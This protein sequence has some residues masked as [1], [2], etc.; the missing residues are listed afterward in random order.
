MDRL[1]VTFNAPY[2]VEIRRE[3]PAEP[4][5]GQVVVHTICSAVSAGSELLI[6]RGLA[7][8]G[9]AVDETIAAL[10]GE[11]GYPIKYG[12][13]AAGRVA[14]LG[15]QVDKSWQDRLVFAF[16]PHESAFVAD[17]ESLIR[18]PEGVSAETA[19]LLPSM[20]T[21][22]S[23]VMDAQP[24]I[25][26]RVAI[27]GQGVVGLLVTSLLAGWP[28]EM[29][30]TADRIQRRRQLSAALGAGASLDPD[31]P[32]IVAQAS[33]LLDGDGQASGADLVLELSGNPAALDLAISLCGY[34]SRILIGSWYGARRSEL[35]LGGRFHR[36][37]IQVSSSQVSTLAPRW[38]GRWT[39]Q[40]RLQVAWQALAGLPLERLITHRFPVQQAAE[41]YRLLDE[42]PA[43]ALQV[44]ITYE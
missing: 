13:A 21:A 25:G 27:L 20:E 34:D 2:A 14:L 44:L 4:G 40:R 24:V 17:T 42:Y 9:M 37:H 23:L 35:A 8:D 32:D 19:A 6:Y 11:F 16:N 22:V 7:P 10:G 39:K 5:P 30:L 41:A 26:E 15:E 18:V 43:D 3:P 28:L 1:A 33:A 29:L 31:D 36:D 12:Y 38:R